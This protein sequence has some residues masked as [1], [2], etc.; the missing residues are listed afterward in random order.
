M[1]ILV[2][3]AGAV[4]QVFGRHLQLGGHDVTFY[5]RNRQV[6]HLS[7]GLL[8]YHL[9]QCQARKQPIVFNSFEMITDRHQIAAKNWEQ[10]YLCLPSNALRSSLHE[11]LGPNTGQATVIAIQPGLNDRH[12]VTQSFGES[13]VVSG[14]ITFTSYAAPLPGE[15]VPCLALLTGS[16][17]L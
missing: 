17:R 11:A 14:M 2:V 1:N 8:L 10:V 15:T 16:R 4:G 9:N 7:E 12:L 5:V 6:D 3:G 13:R